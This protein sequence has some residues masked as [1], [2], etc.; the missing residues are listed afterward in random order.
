ME[1]QCNGLRKKRALGSIGYISP[2]GTT[3][4]TEAPA[5]R[6]K[7]F[8]YTA[9]LSSDLASMLD[10]EDFSDITF[11]I[12]DQPIKANKKLLAA[13]NQYFKGLLCGN[14]RE[15]TENVIRIEDTGFEAFRIVLQFLYSGL[16]EEISVECAYSVLPLAHKYM[17]KELQDICV[18][19]LKI[20][21]STVNA[22]ETLLVANRF[23]LQDLR[24][25]ALDFVVNHCNTFGEFLEDPNLLLEIAE[26]LAK[27]PKLKTS[28]STWK[29]PSFFGQM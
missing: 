8:D 24:N 16:L 29:A 14:L 23:D 12:G 5:K 3:Y 21:M 11:I 20:D 26:R 27:Q 19:V 6:M 7:F 28:P 22:K 18:D 25:F 10:N 17:I 4:S 1:Q 9:K 13:R 15:S 2:F